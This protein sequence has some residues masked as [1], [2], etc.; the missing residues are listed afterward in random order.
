MYESYGNA[1]SHDFT[2]ENKTD[3]EHPTWATDSA[4][5][6]WVSAKSISLNDLADSNDL[7]AITELI[8]G[9]FNGYDD[10]Q[11][12][13]KRAHCVLQVNL[14]LHQ[15]A[16]LNMDKFNL[17]D[18]TSNNSS[19][20]AFG[21]GLWHDPKSSKHG[22]T[23]DIDE[24]KIGYLRFLELA[25]EWDAKNKTKHGRFGFRTGAMMILHAEKRLRELD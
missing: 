19:G 20:G 8:N 16:N 4:G 25:N 13:L 15:V 21:W 10:R 7:I 23:K 5:W 1:V 9:A 12:Y 6:F 22:V 18:S 24:S 3:L 11:L 14:C 17:S 2:D